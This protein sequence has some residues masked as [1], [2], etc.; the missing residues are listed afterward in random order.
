M[1]AFVLA[2]LAPAALWAGGVAG[3]V[4]GELRKAELDPEQCYRVRDLRFARDELK[5]YFNDGYLIFAKPIHGQVVSAVFSGEVEGGGAELL[6][7]PPFV[8]ERKSLAGFTHSPNLDVRFQSN[9]M[10]FTDDSAAE[11]LASARAAGSKKNAEMGFLLKEKWNSVMASFV[12]SFEVR[13]VE[14]LLSPRRKEVGFLYMAL[15]GSALGNFDAI[16][17]PRGSRQISIGQVA[18]R[19]ERRY[20]DVWTN[21]QANS[22]RMGRRKTP[23]MDF[24]PEQYSI[25]ATID[26]S[27]L[28]KAVT[29]L[30]LTPL[31]TERTIAL[32]L[33][34]Q[35]RVT[36]AK[37]DGSPAEA[38]SPE[39]LRA[40]LMR[41]NE[42]QILLITADHEFTAGKPVDLEI[43]HEGTVISSAGDGVYYVGARGIWYPNRSLRF[44]PYE[45][46]FRYPK[47]LDLVAT[48]DLVSEETEGDW[49]ISRRKTSAPV[50]F[51]G[52]NL[53]NYQRA[54]VQKGGLT[55]EVCANRKLEAAL[56]P[57]PK[58]MEMPPLSTTPWG[59]GR[60]QRT[61]GV[62]MIPA[63]APD[64]TARLKELAAEIA[65]TFDEM[66]ARF[67][68][69]PVRT[70][71][72]SPIPGRFGQGF[73]GLVYLSTL[74]YLDPGQRP[75]AKTNSLQQMFFSEIL[76]AHEVA[77]Q[78][79][80]NGVMP[81]DYQ[82]DWLMEALA[83]YSALWMLE[84][85]KGPRV[86][87]SIL[88]EYRNDLLRK[89]TDG[90]TIESAGPVTMGHRLSSSQSPNAWAAIV[91]EKGSWI[92]HMLRRRMG[93]ER[94]GKMLAE[95]YQSNLFH[96]VS[97]EQFRQL[98]QK[99]LPAGSPDP[100]LENFFEQWVY[101]SGIPA[102]KLT[103][104]V[105]GKAPK[106]RLVGTITQ[107][108]VDEE[109][110][111]YVPVEIQT[112]KARPVV[113]WVA[114]SNE[115]A[116]FEMGLTA[117]PARVTLDPGAT[118]MRK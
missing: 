82:D 84:R 29:R 114:T 79:W 22:F 77:H 35:V 18:F 16:W 78:W 80:G 71:T 118:L 12:A 91:Y 10:V 30:R 32:E 9:V 25:D 11:L 109:F 90:R 67:G 107:T 20:F 41:S 58:L 86:L 74:A 13:L 1:R 66:A 81:A 68:A 8:R 39:S 45:V 103:W 44:A 85:G 55:V 87:D 102:L 101:G 43:A 99:Y 73:P 65:G 106:L 94:F 95:F 116:Q 56:Q 111:V 31:V 112:G 70:L 110:S 42:N 49:K 34:Q 76:H 75:L 89:E 47:E 7:M 64:P 92:L 100:K 48:G 26:P 72:I 105:K 57:G 60:Q 54:R 104:S 33:S 36:S 51:F 14:D 117:M 23:E 19:D 108:G 50:R 46:T 53:G 3:E 40:N 17:D 96:S 113:K 83:N 98:A 5:V 61:P 69:P 21:F 6:A 2:V 63:P 15:G 38:Y 62:M 93:D 115:P 88:D 52:F 4:A 37:V 27:L 28:L 97:T 24:K 59:R